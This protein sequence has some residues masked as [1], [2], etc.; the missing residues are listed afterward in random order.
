VVPQFALRGTFA[1]GFR[2]PGIAEAGH[3]GTGS[4]TTAPVDPLRCPFTGKPSDCGL[5]YAATLSVGNPKLQP[6]RSRSYTV[7]FVLEPLQRTNFTAD[8]FYVRRNQEIVPAPLGLVPPVRGVQQPGTSYPG[9]IIYYPQPYV[10]AADSKTTGVDLALRSEMP[11]GRLGALTA[12][13]SGTYLFHSQQTFFDP[14]NGNQ[15]FEYAGTAGPTAV[16]G[17]VGTP[18]LRG[19]F[20]LDWTRSP[21]SLGAEL[22]FRSRMQGIDES[23]SGT[24]CIQLSVSNPYCYIS[25]FSYL[26][27]YGQY[28]LSEHTQ[29]GATVTN[30][31][32]RL[33]PLNTVTYGGTD[34]NPS[35][36]QAGAVGRFYGLTLR[37][38]F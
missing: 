37:Y 33:P 11:L 28:Q 21:V 31:T 8:Y 14:I 7:G 18:R 17:A 25:S 6:E 4:S 16:G 32:N 22:Y 1:R 10:N 3:S 24:Q 38:R 9:P 27:L 30:V 15:S 35:L 2:A 29:L 20:G 26:D 19:S 34:Y 13:L 36:D 12:E 5:G 23:T